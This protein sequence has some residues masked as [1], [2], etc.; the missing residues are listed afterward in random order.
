MNRKEFLKIV[1]IGTIAV[2]TIP[3][4]VFK[5]KDDGTLYEKFDYKFSDLNSDLQHHETKN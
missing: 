1:G 5:S 3:T 2:S 4:K